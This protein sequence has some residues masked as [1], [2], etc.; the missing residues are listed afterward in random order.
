MQ[1]YIEFDINGVSYHASECST[2]DG[3][4]WGN[5]L[6]EEGD[7]VPSLLE[8]QQAAIVWEAGRNE[9]RREARE[10]AQNAEWEYQHNQSLREP[11]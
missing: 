11:S 2:T 9:R 7:V 8:A 5:E 6:R 10:A 4:C 1:D 3:F